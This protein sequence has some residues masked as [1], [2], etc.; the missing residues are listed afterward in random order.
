VYA[1]SPD[2]ELNDDQRRTLQTLPG[3]ELVAKELEEV[4][5]AV[6]VAES[7]RDRDESIKR[8]ATEE[9]EKFRIAKAVSETKVGINFCVFIV[10]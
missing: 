4:K 3:L 2:G 6:E 10:F 5:K 8:E 7:E 1:S 9:A